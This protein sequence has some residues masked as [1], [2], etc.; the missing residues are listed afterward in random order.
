M[1]VAA[2]PAQVWN[3]LMFYEQIEERPPLLL[4]LF[5][6]MPIRTEGRKSEVGDQTRCLY[7]SGYLVK[8]LTRIDRGRLYAFEVVEQQL[9][10]GGGLSLLGGWYALRELPGRRTEIETATR[11]E[12]RR[13][14]R[15]LWRPVEVAVCHL[16]HRHI[17]RATRAA[18]S[19][20]AAR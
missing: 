17:L 6:P 15:R 11:Y 14:P 10:F 19:S 3:V 7:Q 13:R 18:A 5:L 9:P 12:S 8:R 20:R 2:S 16:F 1:E 4:R